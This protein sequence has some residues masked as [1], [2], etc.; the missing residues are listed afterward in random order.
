M[1]AQ[2]PYHKRRPLGTSAP[3]STGGDHSAA[4]HDGD[5]TRQETRTYFLYRFISPRSRQIPVLQWRG[6]NKQ[7]RKYPLPYPVPEP[8]A[9]L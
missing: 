1:A 6:K 2:L 7:V 8:F 9:Q 4:A 5:Q 3:H